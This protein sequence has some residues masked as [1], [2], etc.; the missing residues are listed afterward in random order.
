MNSRPNPF[1]LHAKPNGGPRRPR[2]ARPSS[3]VALLDDR[4]VA[5]LSQRDCEPGSEPELGRRGLIRVLAR[6]LSDAGIEASIKRVYWYTDR[7]DGMLFD[8]QV[9]R[10]LSEA[11]R[12]SGESDS[13]SPDG[14]DAWA[15]IERDLA[16]LS[17]AQA[18]ELIVV[19]SDDDRLGAAIDQ[20]Q[21]RGTSVCL[22]AD[23]SL[24]DFGAL[25]VEEP[26]WAAL[27]ALADRRLIVR[28]TDLLDLR[29]P[30]RA[31]GDDFK[32][33]SAS[34]EQSLIEEVVRA[35][36]AEQSEDA[37]ED[38]RAALQVSPGIP[39]DVDRALLLQTRERFV[40]PLS[41]SEKKMMRECLREVVTSTSDAEG[42]AATLA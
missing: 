22:L 10:V 18:Y 17:Q 23:D 9:T 1:A 35:W 21:L 6:L 27:L 41:F 8:D 30:S 15:A 4:F 39:Q 24:S 19:G 38:L 16:A 12:A 26:D 3:C 42:E 40:R 14:S 37:R 11:V 25:R 2:V 28:P 32:G 31:G 34:G 5:W 13:P 36:W 7:P 29:G 33:E 20:A